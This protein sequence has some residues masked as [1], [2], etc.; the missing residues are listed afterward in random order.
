MGHETPALSVEIITNGLI[1]CKS[2]MEETNG[3]Y[4]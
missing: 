3:S 1:N 2:D 4:I